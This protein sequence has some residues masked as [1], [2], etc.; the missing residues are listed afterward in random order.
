MYRKFKQ[1]KEERKMYA[2]HNGERVV[3]G[4]Q[5]IGNT[6]DQRLDLTICVW[7]VR[8]EGTYLKDI[9]GKS[10]LNIDKIHF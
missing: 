6:A 10:D 3:C 8:Q 9:V 5:S 4:G 2:M 1:Y 7:I